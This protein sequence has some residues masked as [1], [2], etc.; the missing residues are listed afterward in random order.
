MLIAPPAPQTLFQGYRARTELFFFG[1][2]QHTSEESPLSVR[3]P[4]I[5]AC[6]IRL[7]ISHTLAETHIR[8]ERQRKRQR[9]MR[10]TKR[11]Q[12][13]SKTDVIIL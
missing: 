2:A 5:F 9:E 8:G 3:I 10:L 6:H 11:N 12:Q 4:D 1:L 13:T 7:S